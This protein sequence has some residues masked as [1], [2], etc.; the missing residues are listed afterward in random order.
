MTGVGQYSTNPLDATGFDGLYL[1]LSSSRPFGEDVELMNDE[2]TRVEGHRLTSVGQPALADSS[3]REFRMPFSSF[4][5]VSEDCPET[6]LLL[7]ARRTRGLSL[8][9]VSGFW[10][11]LRVHEVGFYH[12]GDAARG[13]VVYLLRPSS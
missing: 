3:V 13:E 11:D 6:S 2:P 9:A 7:D 12:Q 1:C 5:A 8:Y 10:G 4:S